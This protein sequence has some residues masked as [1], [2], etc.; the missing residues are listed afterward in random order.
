MSKAAEIVTCIE[1]AE[2]FHKLFY[3]K[4]DKSRQTIGK[5][6]LDNATLN[7]NGNAVKGKTEI[8]GFLQKLPISHTSVYSVDAQPLM[9]SSIMIVTTGTVKFQSTNSNRDQD[10]SQT[11]VLKKT[12]TKT[13]KVSFDCF[14]LINKIESG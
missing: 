10:F 4:L 6:Y 9:D 7:W 8:S 11:F 1:T 5:L 13:M 2:T 12:D 3:E 14:R